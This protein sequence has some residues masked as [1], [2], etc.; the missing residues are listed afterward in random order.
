GARLGHP[1]VD[2]ETIRI[3]GL[4]EE[5]AGGA[6]IVR[7]L[8]DVR[9]EGPGARKQ[10]TDGGNP[11]A[12]QDVANDRVLVDRVIERLAHAAVGERLLLDVESRVP[13]REPGCLVH[14]DARRLLEAADPIGRNR[15][16]EMDATPA[17]RA[18]T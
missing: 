7:V 5:L 9:L 16:G 2:L 10:R 14:A 12:L 18:H 11:G 8:V 1:E 6:R 3:A 15:Q 17:G 4:G 13:D